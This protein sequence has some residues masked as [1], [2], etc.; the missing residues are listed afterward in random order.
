MGLI[1]LLILL[2]V[3]F[4]GGGYGYGRRAGWGR[5]HYVYGGGGLS[6]V[7]IVIIL[8]IDLLAIGLA[9]VTAVLWPVLLVLLLTLSAT[10]ALLFKIPTDLTGL[11][12]SLFLLAGFITLFAIAGVWIARKFQPDAIKT[13]LTLN[14]NFATPADLA[15]VMPA[16]T[17]VLPFLLLMMVSARLPLANPTPL[18]GLALLLTVLLLGVARMFSLTWMP[19]VGLACVT[20]LECAWHFTHFSPAR[21]GQPFNLIL[22][23]YAVFFV[24]FAIF[25]FIFLRHFSRTAVPWATAAAVG[26]PQFFLIHRLVSEVYPNPWMGLLPAMFSLPGLLSVWVILKKIPVDVRSR[27]AQLAWFGGVALFFITLIF[28]I[29]FDRQWITLGWA[30]EGAAL[31]WLFR[32]VPHPGLRLAGTG[33]LVAS[34][35][36]LAFNPAVLEYHARAPVPI[37]N[38]YLYAYGLVSVCLFVGAKL[39]A[40]PRNLIL[41]LDAPPVLGALGTVLTFLLLSIEIADYFSDLGSTL[42]FQ[43]SGNFARDMT[44]SIAWALFALGLLIYGIMKEIVAARYTAM[45]LLI[46]TLLK[47]F[48]HDLAQ[49]GPLY[50][51]VAFIAVAI[52]AMLASFSYQKFFS[53]VHP[54]AVL[55]E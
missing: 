36:R 31:L 55:K 34:F 45:V 13:G 32:R 40:P 51:I 54:E 47:L 11:P 16:C 6:L 14:G 24:L 7:W 20:A 37:A 18:F 44:Y 21:V 42:T 12:S 39:L 53:K 28:P 29:Q 46:V 5:S 23:W 33:L 25:P 27:M 48:F 49:L 17:L 15:A 43:F 4:A 52:I 10:G 1:L 22:A 38:W 41:K 26:L 35:A 30:F 9:V 2:Y 8:L 19:A 3:V 50:R